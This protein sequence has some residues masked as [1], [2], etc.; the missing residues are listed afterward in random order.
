MSLSK[1][2]YPLLSTVQHRKTRPDMTEKNVD[3][4]VKNKQKQGA[5]LSAKAVGGFNSCKIN[6]LYYRGQI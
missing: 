3:W 5:F 2:L 4:D 6:F 1:K